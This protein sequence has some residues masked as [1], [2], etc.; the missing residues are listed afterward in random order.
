M[1]GP[2]PPALQVLSWEALGPDG[3]VRVTTDKGTY[4][5]DKLVLSAGAWMSQLVPELEV[6]AG[7]QRALG[8]GVQGLGLGGPRC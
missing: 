7:A 2:T 8:V 5:A 4:E 6:G 3:G 1:C